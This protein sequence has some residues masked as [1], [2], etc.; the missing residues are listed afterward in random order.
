MPPGCKSGNGESSAAPTRAR[1]ITFVRLL[2]ALWQNPL[3]A[4]TEEFFE[5]PLI[6]KRLPFHPIAVV[7]DP[8]AIRRVLSDNAGNY[9]KDAFQRRMFS[10]LDGGLLTAEGDA[11]HAQRRMLAPIFSAKTVRSFAPAMQAAIDAMIERWSER[12][13]DEIVDLAVEITDFTLNTLER[14]IFTDGLGRSADKVRNAMRVYFDQ[15]GRI[16]PLG[17]IGL[18]GVLPRLGRLSV[19]PALR[20]FEDAMDAMIALRRQRLR[21]QPQGVPRDIL[22]LLLEAQDDAT[23]QPIAEREVRANILT[24]MSAG[25]ETTANA[26]TWTLYLLSQS[27]QWRERVR[28]EAERELDGPA[29]N[30]GARLTVTRAVIEETLRLYPSLVAISRVSL[31][32]DEL[33]GQHIRAGTLIV[34][35]PYVLHRHAALWEAPDRFDPGRFLPDQRARIDRY[36]YMPFG[37]GARAC[38]GQVF[39]LQEAMLAVARIVAEFDI[40]VVPGHVVTPLHRVTLRPRDGLPVR[41]HRRPAH[42]PAPPP[43]LSE[44]SAPLAPVSRS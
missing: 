3:D 6:V 5:Q 30:V 14:T 4:W 34:I 31:G 19:R 25:H 21:D 13:H 10:A 23:G 8:R 40:E 9:R 44:Q 42:A 20:L 35:S 37:A 2:K 38:I 18:P 7:S 16:D 39:A 24:F 15:V 43:I 28:E 11:W 12:G 41:L 1:R 26:I 32:P 27:P 36:A 22:T 33:A 29:E 17:L